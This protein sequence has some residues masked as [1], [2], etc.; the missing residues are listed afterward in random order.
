MIALALLLAVLAAS[1]TA[2]WIDPAL[3]VGFML[4]LLVL[5]MD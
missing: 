4:A 2:V 5:A 3:A 1:G